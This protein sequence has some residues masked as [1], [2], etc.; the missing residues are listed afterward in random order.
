M[1]KIVMGLMLASLLGSAQAVRSVLLEPERVAV[2][3]NSVTLTP[4]LVKQAIV[5]GGAKYEWT[6]VSD[7]PGKLQLKHNKQN[8]HEAVVEVS[9]DAT[10]YQIRYASSVNLKYDNKDGVATIHPAYNIWV[11]NLS[12]AITAEVGA[13][14][15]AN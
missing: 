14:S 4:E 13:P 3:S 8:K 15:A 1:K 6:V 2:V 11:G 12:R 9:Y 10:G 5:R 7:E